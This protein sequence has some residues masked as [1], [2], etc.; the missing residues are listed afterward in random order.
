[1]AVQVES[2]IPRCGDHV[3][4]RPSGENWLVAYAEG[5]DIAWTGWPDG[6]A[7]LHDCDVTY[8]CTDAEHAVAVEQ[9]RHVRDDSR[10]GRVLRLYAPTLSSDRPDAE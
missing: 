3:L 10:C 8:R 6:M 1:M 5:D 4:H 7:R 9:W 2:Y